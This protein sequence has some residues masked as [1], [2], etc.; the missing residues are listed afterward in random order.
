MILEFRNKRHATEFLEMMVERVQDDKPNQLK[1]R[2]GTVK[3]KKFYLNKRTDNGIQ[4]QE[5]E[6][7]WK[8]KNG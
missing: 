7:R 8:V 5:I 6:V 3:Y 2:T 4:R 1:K